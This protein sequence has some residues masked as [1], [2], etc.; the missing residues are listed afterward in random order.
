MGDFNTTVNE[1]ENGYPHAITYGNL[2]S[3]AL[4]IRHAENISIDNINIAT[5]RPDVRFP[6][7]VDDVKGLQIKNTI[8]QGADGTKPFVKGNSVRDHSVE[9]PLGWTEGEFF[10]LIDD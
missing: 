4:F 2:P 5:E 1:D 8:W 7:V 3:H 10:D 6:I 9:A